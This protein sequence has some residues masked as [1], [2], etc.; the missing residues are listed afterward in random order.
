MIISIEYLPSHTVDAQLIYCHYDSYEGASQTP[1]TA[2]D[3]LRAPFIAGVIGCLNPVYPAAYWEFS[4]L[5]PLAPSA[6]SPASG[7]R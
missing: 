5:L 7:L 4:T 2:K 6:P 3:M 1:T